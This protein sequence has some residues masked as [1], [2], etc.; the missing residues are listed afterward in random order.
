MDNQKIKV[1]QSI[2][3]IC[4]AFTVSLNVAFRAHYFKTTGALY[5]ALIS[6]LS[7]YSRNLF[8]W[9]R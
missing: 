9:S 6:S 4:K 7:T 1:K 5:L 2:I 8:Q 3:V